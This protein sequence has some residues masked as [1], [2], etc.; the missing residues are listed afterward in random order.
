MQISGALLLHG[1]PQHGDATKLETQNIK[2]EH[3]P[4]KEVTWL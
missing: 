1:D 3:E 4:L 2:I